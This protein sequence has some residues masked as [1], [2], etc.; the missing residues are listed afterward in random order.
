MTTAIAHVGLA[1]AAFTLA[2]AGTMSTR[3]WR[4]ARAAGSRCRSRRPW[5]PPNRCS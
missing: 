5:R 1:A 3:T 2:V 4:A